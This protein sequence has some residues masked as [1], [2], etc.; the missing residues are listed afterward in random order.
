MDDLIPATEAEAAARRLEQ[1]ILAG[2]LAPD[3]KLKIRELKARYGFGASPMREALA[4]LS[5]NGLV[6]LR[7]Q[8]G[9]RVAPVSHQELADITATRKLVEAEAIRLAIKNATP[10]WEDEIVASFHV[11]ERQV[12]RFCDGVDKRL[13]VYEEKHQRFHCSLI[14]ACPLITLTTFCE[15][16]Y[17]RTR[18][19]RAL[20]RGYGFSKEAV[21]AEHRVL[22]DAVLRREVPSAVAAARAHIGLTEDLIAQFMQVEADR[23]P[24]GDARK[25]RITQGAKPALRRRY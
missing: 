3:A 4:R 17:I 16:L 5:A 22:M 8:R 19:Y 21:V 9:F 10:A 15:D 7:G 11:F 20:N 18:R 13:D 1:D 6:Q 23:S 24:D 14:A 25:T 2:V 12:A